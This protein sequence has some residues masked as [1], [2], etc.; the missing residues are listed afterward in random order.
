MKKTNRIASAGAKRIQPISS[1]GGGV[2]PRKTINSN[3]S[4]AGSNITSAVN[5]GGAIR[6]P[7]A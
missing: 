5:A 1:I 6:P 2:L 3:G 7:S 4:V